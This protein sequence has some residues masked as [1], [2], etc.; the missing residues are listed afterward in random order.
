[1]LG[2]A[3]L[4]AGQSVLIGAL[5]LQAARRRR[6]EREL[7]ASQAELRGSYDRIRDLGGRLLRAQED[8]AG[9]HL[10]RAARRH[11]PA[12][13]GAWH[14][15]GDARATPARRGDRLVTDAYERTQA[16]A[17][18]VRDLSHRLHPANLSLV[19]LTRALER[20]ARDFSNSGLTIT[21]THG[22]VP[23]A[24]PTEVTLCL[25]RI[26][27]ESLQ[28]VLKHSGARAATMHLEA[29]RSELWLTVADQGAGCELRRAGRGLGLISMEE[30][31]DQVGGSLDIRSAPGA[32]TRVNA[33][34]PDRRR[35]PG[36]DGR[37]M[38]ADRRRTL[39]AAV[40]VL[41]LEA[42]IVW[43]VAT[44]R[45][46]G[47]AAVLIA[48]LVSGALA[49]AL[50]PAGRALASTAPRGGDPPERLKV[51]NA[52]RADEERFHLLADGAPV[53]LWVAGS[54]KLCTYFNRGWLQFTGRTLEQELGHG[55]TEGVL[56]EHFQRCLET[57]EAAF[58]KRE[59]FTIE[60]Q[61]RRRDG[62]YRW[63]L[64]SGVPRVGPDGAFAGYVGSAIDITDLKTARSMLAEFG[65]RLLQAHE[66]ERTRIARELHDDI[67]QRLA[68]LTM[69]LDSVAGL[70]PGE[71]S[72]L[73]R[74]IGAVS[75]RAIELARDVQA[76]SHRLH[77]SKLDHL[78]LVSAS[79]GLC[80][81]LSAQ[82]GIAVE[83][84]ADGMPEQVP[85]N[86]ALCV[87]RVLQEAVGNAL[88]HGHGGAVRARLCGTADEIRLEVID[89]GRGFDL[90]AAMRE[91][92]LGLISMH[93]RIGLVHGRIGI[94]SRP[95]SGTRV[96]AAIPLT[97][98]SNTMTAVR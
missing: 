14:R 54:D 76:L 41:V 6:A 28:N 47:G 9:A 74:R 98:A 45:P 46:P 27:Q 86:L 51:E 89:D 29:V 57:Y 19:G 35:A 11:Q 56:A 48:A 66:T 78:G 90:P 4:L 53:M 40:A 69:D 81:E 3:A 75:T 92:G 24:L 68:V 62:Q 77:S 83:F 32:G 73:G 12:D 52:L 64:D 60:Y 44:A 96:D 91:G 10:A 26:A 84:T 21:F 38:R 25:F 50:T 93:E 80:R 72:D 34:V 7:K 55:W 20:L 30:R 95:G 37:M 36:V 2:A 87:F 16:V 70:M 94:E 58:A 5:L 49:I 33:R 82:H 97:A 63:M 1:M 88:K 85:P 71:K 18:R 43:W 67:G 61:R 17:R 42:A 59:P 31:V 8:E 13:R 79:A 23:D 15:P 39:L 22:E 65:Q